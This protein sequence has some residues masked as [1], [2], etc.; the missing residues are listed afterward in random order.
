VHR[1]AADSSRMQALRCVLALAA[2]QEHGRRPL[3]ERRRRPV[4]DKTARQ[5][6]AAARARARGYLEAPAPRLVEDLTEPATEITAT[7]LTAAQREATPTLQKLSINDQ[8]RACAASC[9]AEGKGAVYAQHLRKAGGTLLRQYLARY[10]CRPFDTIVSK[11]QRLITRGVPRS[12]TAHTVIQ[13]ENAFNPQNIL[14]RPNAVYVTI[15]RDP[16]ARVSSSFF[17]EDGV[18]F[19]SWLDG[20]ERAS[21]ERA[22]DATTFHSHTRVWPLAQQIHE[23]VANYYVQVFSGV[24]SH[25]VTQKHFDAAVSTLSNFDVVLILEHLATPD[26]RKEAMSLLARALPLPPIARCPPSIRP[27][28]VNSGRKGVLTEGQRRRIADLNFYDVKLYE[29][30]V[31]LMNARIAAPRDACAPRNCSSIPDD[32][33]NLLRGED[34]LESCGRLIPRKCRRD[35]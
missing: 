5:Q 24:A 33:L 13:G 7:T 4:R 26:G 17:A 8:R 16:I 11:R 27:R 30:G 23:E 21:Q 34:A 10:R 2:T 14:M 19:E 15:L 32:S 12:R 1:E 25:P 18:H 28:P 20:I 22:K 29:H 35:A 31:T 9:T 3:H 6:A